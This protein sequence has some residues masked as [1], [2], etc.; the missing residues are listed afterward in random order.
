MFTRNLNIGFTLV[1]C[2][3]FD[4]RHVFIVGADTGFNFR[5]TGDI[6]MTSVTVMNS[7]TGT[8]FNRL[9]LQS[10]D[11]NSVLIN[12]CRFG[13][14]RQGI[15]WTAS[16]VGEVDLIQ[17][18]KT[19]FYGNEN[20]IASSS[21]ESIFVISGAEFLE[22]TGYGVAFS[23]NSLKKTVIENCTFKGSVVRMTYCEI[24]LLLSDSLFIESI[25]TIDN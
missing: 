9:R 6:S 8:Y 4:F 23:Y 20:G 21:I 22:N 7:K 17:L 2:N 24:G 5:I 10:S 1:G 16:S 18:N 12:K 25:F 14:N 19:I 15:S 11:R 13:F 3:S